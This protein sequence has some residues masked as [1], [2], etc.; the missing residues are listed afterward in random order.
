M[1]DLIFLTSIS[2]THERFDGFLLFEWQ[3]LARVDNEQIPETKWMM[4]RNVIHGRCCIYA[5]LTRQVKQSISLV[6]ISSEFGSY[7]IWIT[8]YLWIDACCYFV[9]LYFHFRLIRE[10]YKI[11]GFWVVECVW[12]CWHLITQ[13]MRCLCH[14]V[15]ILILMTFDMVVCCEWRQLGTLALPI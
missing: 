7:Y 14:S 11:I 9:I 3:P 10:N 13:Y 4:M 2:I 15:I 1:C 8:P 12:C 5:Q 6:A